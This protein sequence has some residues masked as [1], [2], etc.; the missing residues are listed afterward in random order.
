MIVLERAPVS[1]RLSLL[2]VGAI[3]AGMA[4]VSGIPEDLASLELPE[5]ESRLA[6]AEGQER[7]PVLVELLSRHR[8]DPIVNVV[9]RGREALRMLSLEPDPKTEVEVRLNLAWAFAF[10]GDSDA[11][12]EQ[13]RRAAEIA[14]GVGD[15]GLF[16]EAEYS[17]GLAHW[18]RC[19]L[20]QALAACESARTIQAA[21]S[22]HSDLASTLTLIGAIHRSRSEYA[23][24]L[25][26]HQ[27]ALRL[28]EQLGDVEAIARSQNNLALIFWNLDDLDK[29]KAFLEPVVGVYRD[30]GLR[31]KLAIALNNLGLVLVEM[32]KPRAALEILEECQALYNDLEEPRGRAK[33]LSNL[34]FAH[35]TL[36]Q[37]V[38][39]KS[40][41]LEALSLRER[42]E[43]HWGASR[44]LGSLGALFRQQ[45]RLDQAQIHLERALQA[46]QTA[47]AK[48]EQAELHESLSEVY[49]ALGNDSM[50]LAALRS[51]RALVKELDFGKV[52]EKVLAEEAQHALRHKEQELDRER[53]QRT[54]LAGGSAVLFSL[55][56][57]LFFVIRARSRALATIRR[58]HEELRQASRKLRESEQRYRS[59]F[60]DALVPR[61]IIDLDLGRVVD[62]NQPAAGLCHRS[63]R[64]LEG[65]DVEKLRPGWIA[66][67]L[68]PADERGSSEQVPLEQWIDEHGETRYSQVW[69]SPLPMEGHRRVVVAIQDVT[70]T[71][72]LEEARI[73]SDKLESLGVLA[74]GI[75]HDFNNAL[76]AVVGHVSLAQSV[77]DDGKVQPLLEEAEAALE[78]TKHLTSQLLAFAKGGEPQRR[79]S[80]VASLLREA[81][82]FGRSG[83]AL[84]VH[85]D[86]EEGLWAASLDPGQF[87]QAVCNLV[88]NATQAMPEGGELRVSARNRRGIHPP[89]TSRERGEFVELEFT[90]CGP[91]IPA[92]V[93]DKILDPYFTTKSEG[94]GLGLA[95]AFAVATRHGGW[96]DFESHEG[97]GS[98]FRLCFP[99]TPE[100]VPPRMVS[101]TESVQ[102][103]GFVLVVDDDPAVRRVFRVLLTSL[104][105]RMDAVNDGEQAIQRY[106]E[107]EEAGDGFDVV[108]LDLTIPGGMGG[109]EALVELRRHSPDAVAIVTSGYCR[110]PVM[111]NYREVGFQGALT[112]PFTKWELGQILKRVL[113]V[114]SSGDRAR[115]SSMPGT[116]RNQ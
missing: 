44:S 116:T 76:T 16:A 50:A 77:T 18:Y 64:P 63:E 94:S 68:D 34:G 99:A 10:K 73:R 72:R 37:D 9:E 51:H 27:E 67:H 41:F 114:E 53:Q 78:Q 11:A 26:C 35:Q 80:D 101:R 100:N 17:R 87:R 32:G 70:E 69:V 104:G 42:I 98:C 82:A 109:K 30:R 14:E 6:R 1:L 62:A 4:V 38:E 31:S 12:L 29:A 108:L 13:A 61:L 2:F 85:F 91:G 48:L 24:S 102:G 115:F 86:V 28:A 58:S 81:V 74:G 7:L 95:T 107:A 19:E 93:K 15:Q 110:D 60:E 84:R 45:G 83:S 43:D 88:I 92:S 106:L 47:D 25:D 8:R 46:A 23:A 21:L 71:R 96:L 5:L 20:D 33:A 56:L 112:K 57:A 54:L 36:G 75:A 66:R 89:E 22:R 97:E 39:A 40:Y 3:T 59:V 52:R 65:C 111:S 79:L 90:D 49:E 55:V 105:Y 103:A 113:E